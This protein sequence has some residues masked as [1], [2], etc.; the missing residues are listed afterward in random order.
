M[1]SHP[2]APLAG[3]QQPAQHPE[4]GGLPRPVRADQPENLAARNGQIQMIQRHQFAEPASQPLYLDDVLSH[5]LL[6]HD[7]GIGG[8]GKLPGLWNDK[9]KSFFFFNYE[10]Y[11]QTGGSNAPTLSIP[12]LR[13]GT[14]T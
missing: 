5:R 8:P 10:G 13:L 7:L 11:R 4:R 9:V 1:S 6:D 3:I 12:S 14:A 2:R